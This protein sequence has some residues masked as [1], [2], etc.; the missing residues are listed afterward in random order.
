M[1]CLGTHKLHIEVFALRI[2]HHPIAVTFCLVFFLLVGCATER[3]KRDRSAKVTGEDK[4]VSIRCDATVKLEGPKTDSPAEIQEIRFWSSPT[5]TRVVIGVTSEVSFTHCLLKKDPAVKKPQ[6]LYIELNHARI[7][8][9]VRSYV[10]VMDALLCDARVDQYTPDAVR[11]VLDIRSVDDFKVSSLHNPFR[12]V[13]N[14][15]GVPLKTA[16]KKR[17]NKAMDQPDV[18]VSGGALARQLAH[19][20][21]RIVIDPGHGGKDPGAQGYL[22]GVVEKN[23]T[24]EISRRLARKIRKKLGCEVIL[25]RNGDYYLSLKER[26]AIANRNN[27]DLFISIHTN[28]HTKMASR[29][30]ATYSLDLANDMDAISVAARENATSARNISNIEDILSD[31]MNS[32]KQEGSNRLAGYVQE[33]M[34][35]NLKRRY[36]EVKNKGVKQAPFYVLTGSKMPSILVEVA[37]ITNPKECRRLNTASYQEDVAHAIAK[38]IQHYAEEMPLL[39]ASSTAQRTSTLRP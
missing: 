12:I 8:A 38:G 17:F 29:G 13:V 26:I 37:F 21:T 39:W 28:A 5:Y 33:V 10:P 19:G 16:S 7:G 1:P 23:V 9:G 32:A 4:A 3:A 2:E 24:L 30:I 22:K 14:V 15:R 11:I 31:L 25:T 6:R 27:A 18:Q 20:V 35:K 34:I 36:G